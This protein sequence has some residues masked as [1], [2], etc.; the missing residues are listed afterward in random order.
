M[1]ILVVI[2]C[3]NICYLRLQ[4]IEYSSSLI[5]CVYFVHQILPGQWLMYILAVSH[6][7]P[8]CNRVDIRRPYSSASI[9]LSYVLFLYAW[10]WTRMTVFSYILYRSIHCNMVF[11]QWLIKSSI[12]VLPVANTTVVACPFVGGFVL[13]GFLDNRFYYSP[14]LFTLFWCTDS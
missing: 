11:H 7:Y 13:H 9:W 10:S 1:Y 3:N 14:M 5:I 12:S 2:L 6:F 4:L 8:S